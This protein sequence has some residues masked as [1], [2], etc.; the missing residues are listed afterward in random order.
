MR[1]YPRS[2]FGQIAIAYL[3]TMMVAAL[4]LPLVAS[5]LLK[6]TAGS[7]QQQVLMRQA[8]SVARGLSHRQDWRVDLSPTLR[9]LY[10]TGYD[11][12][13]Y[14]VI[15]RGGRP[16]ISSRLQ[17]VPVIAAAP[18]RSS[19][20]FFST[21]S[22]QGLS[23][24]V[25]RGG[26]DLWIIVSQDM[27]DPGV[28]TDDIV[29][30]F[31]YRFLL[32]LAPIL[33]LLFLI[34]AVLIRR[35]T[36]AVLRLSRRAAEVGP[37]RL[38]I[39]LASNNLPIEVA[40]LAEATNQALDRLETGFRVQ[41]EFVANVA[42]ELRTP[43]SLLQLQ[44]DGLDDMAP[45]AALRATIERASHVVSQLLDLASLEQL[46]IRPDERFNLDTMVRETV[47]TIAPMI[48][49]HGRTI[50][51]SGSEEAHPVIGRELLISLALS[52]LIDN[53][54]R[55][56]PS[57]THIEVVVHSDGS[58]AVEDNGPG[59][60]NTD[61]D[62]LSRRFWR[63]DH[64]RSDSAGIGLSIVKRIVEAHGGRLNVANRPGGGAVFTIK[65]VPSHSAPER[66]SAKS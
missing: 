31:L 14:S 17:S 11:G 32:G 3:A 29:T 8:Q 50:A 15:D 5:L 58:V 1:I 10:A 60:A 49:S 35:S 16:V 48:F 23:V 61:L 7:Y 18:R 39:R 41:A 25:R 59:I 4:A 40:P 13:A 37:T 46:A 38:D 28:V 6:D 27:S 44:I 56:S 19:P 30:S 53:A 20:S 45:K 9:Q 64:A 42:H 52:N 63:A 51:L 2:L 22:I 34:N 36:Q 33:L 66:D 57:G 12:R 55:H 62:L 54:A 21:G 65:L 47:E 43:L 26:S 24:P